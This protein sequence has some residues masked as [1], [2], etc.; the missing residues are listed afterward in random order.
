MDGEYDERERRMAHFLAVCEEAGV[1]VTQQRI[2]IFREVTGSPE[3]PDAEMLFRRLRQRLPTLSLDTVY[4]N[5][6]FLHDLGL[7]TTLGL[8]RERTRFDP[9]T[10]PHQH[11]VCTRCGAV[12]DFESPQ[13]DALALPDGIAAL[14]RVD[15][16][17][18]ELRGVCRRCLAEPAD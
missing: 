12:H 2:E 14:G 7:I 8:P 4:R 6:W 17:H 16:R 11:F 15:S 1:R 9:N 13:L 3:H 10:E 5:L 18:W